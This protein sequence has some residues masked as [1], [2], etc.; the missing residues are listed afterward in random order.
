RT[1]VLLFFV[2]VAIQPALAAAKPRQSNEFKTLEQDAIR[3]LHAGKYPEAADAASRALS[4]AERQY[5]PND[6]RLVGAL[7]QLGEIY[8]MQGRFADAEP[9]CERALAVAEKALGPEHLDVATA[10]DNLGTVYQNR[11][12]S[13][14]AEPLL[15]RALAIR[16]KRLGSAD[17]S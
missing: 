11:N 4:A 12:R 8:R 16:E 1:A 13:A 6:P 9:V 17:L 14:D 2:V 7:N 15:K 3:L 10:L 5:G